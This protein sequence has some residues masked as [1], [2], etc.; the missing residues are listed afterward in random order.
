MMSIIKAAHCDVVFNEQI[1]IWWEERS[2]LFLSGRRCWEGSMLA[3]RSCMGAYPSTQ[4]GDDTFVSHNMMLH[5]KTALIQESSLY[6]Y[7][8]NRNNTCNNDHFEHLL[9]TSS[10]IYSGDEKLDILNSFG[11]KDLHKPL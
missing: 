3:K 6:C 1:F 4:K 11:I 10:R 2:I 9:K 7:T 5:H 8:I